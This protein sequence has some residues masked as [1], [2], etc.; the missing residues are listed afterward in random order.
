MK[1][2]PLRRISKKRQAEAPERERVRLATFAR[3]NWTCLLWKQDDIAGPCVGPLTFHHLKK[4]SAGG[5][6]TTEN[7]ATLCAGHNTW[8][9]DNPR[10][11]TKMGLVIR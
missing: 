7:G 11:A 10:L 9:E 1:R 2:S 6:Y 8:V 4:A 5:A 3:D